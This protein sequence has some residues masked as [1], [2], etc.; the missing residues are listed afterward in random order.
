MEITN[1]NFQELVETQQPLYPIMLKDIQETLEI[2]TRN[3]CDS[4][5]FNLATGYGFHIYLVTTLEEY[6]LL[7]KEKDLIST[8]LPEFEDKTHEENQSLF[9]KQLFLTTDE[10]GYVIYLKL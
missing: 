4:S 2:N 8:Y 7:I 3:Y 9:I 10:S 1:N 5:S 6:I